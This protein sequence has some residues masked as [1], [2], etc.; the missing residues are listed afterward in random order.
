M[1]PKSNQTGVTLIELIAFLV[2]AGVA[3][4]GLLK[5][6]NQNQQQSVDPVIRIQ[7]LELAQAQLDDVLARKFDENTATGGVPACGATDGPSCLGIT[8]PDS[9]FDDVGDFNNYNQAQGGFNITVSVTEAGTELGLDQ[10]QARK[11]S[12]TVTPP[13]TSRS[14]AG[15]PVTLT[16]YKV[17]F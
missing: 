1:N 8:T 16:A 6:F 3:L 11:I 5:M 15:T 4:V 2:I 12:V 10:A 7:A 17:N 14:A 13:A 9:D